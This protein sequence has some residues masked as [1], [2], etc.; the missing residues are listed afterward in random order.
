MMSNV[1][2]SRLYF[3][4]FFL[5][6]KEKSNQGQCWATD[7]ETASLIR[8]SSL[9]FSYSILELTLPEEL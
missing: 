8:C 7:E 6:K 3:S 4:S 9:Y 5:V 2:E 1:M